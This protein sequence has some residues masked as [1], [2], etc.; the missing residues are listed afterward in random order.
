LRALSSSQKKTILLDLVILLFCLLGVYNFIN[1]ADLPFLITTQNSNLVISSVKD[2]LSAFKKGDI[3]VSLENFELK[4]IEEVEIFL[5]G[6]K[7]NDELKTTIQREGQIINLKLNTQ[8]HYS[9]GYVII[10]S[11]VGLMFFSVALIV[12]IKCDREELAR[13]FHWSFIFTAMII[14]MTWGNY[15]LLPLHLGFV[16]RT[17]FH[18]GYL[19]APVFFLQFAIIFPANLNLKKTNIFKVLFIL[20]TILFLVLSLIFYMFIKNMSLDLMRTYIV[21]FDIS[22]LFIVL[23]ILSAIFVFAHTY[24]TTPIDA[25]V[26]WDHPQFFF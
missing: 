11:L 21:A 24:T 18:I 22:S 15:S 5:D 13:V 12:L 19:L 23:V 9:T 16:T 7:P 6:K 25:W 3:V 1:K 14:M 10:A 26:E 8:R 4:T 17:G 2:S 20:S